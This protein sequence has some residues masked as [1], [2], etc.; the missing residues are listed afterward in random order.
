MSF[1][2]TPWSTPYPTLDNVGMRPSSNF[3]AAAKPYKIVIKSRKYLGREMTYDGADSCDI[4]EYTDYYCYDEA[5]FMPVRCRDYK[6][7]PPKTTKRPIDASQCRG[8]WYEY[9][10]GPNFGYCNCNIRKITTDWRC[11]TSQER[12]R[13]CIQGNTNCPCGPKPI[14]REYKCPPGTCI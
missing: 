2:N 5:N 14:K 11:P 10:D 7:T 9:P 13:D 3:S 8:K 6:I 12:V 4:W 1:H